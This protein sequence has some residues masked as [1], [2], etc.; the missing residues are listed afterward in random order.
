[1]AE[2]F[3]TPFDD[4]VV[5]VPSGSPTGGGV[6]GGIPVDQGGADPWPGGTP[7]YN[8][9]AP[10]AGGGKETANSESG[11]PPRVDL[12]GVDGARSG[13]IRQRDIDMETPSKN[14]AGGD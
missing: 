2:S 14:L 4:A 6:T 1:M 10:N 8:A 9:I 11:L 13:V 12:H 5:P 3:P 7:F